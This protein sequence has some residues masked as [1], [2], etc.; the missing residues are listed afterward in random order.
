MKR[1]FLVG[2]AALA[3]GCGG[4]DPADAVVGQP[5]VVSALDVQ[6]RVFTPRC[7]LSGCH[8]GIGAPMDLDLGSVAASVANTVDVPSA[9]V[10]SLMRVAPNDAP[11]SYLYRKVSGDPNIQGD[12]M[13]ASG[14]PLNATELALIETWIEQGAR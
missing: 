5:G 10:P 12:P 4:G 8:V 3:A 7:A 6:T 9:E 14:P 11:G 13:P 2:C 1:L